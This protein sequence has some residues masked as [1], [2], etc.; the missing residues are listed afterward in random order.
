MANQ[1]FISV[2]EFCRAFAV[3]RTKF[4]QLVAAGEVETA[5]VGRRRLVLVSSALDFASRCM[6]MQK[7]SNS[8]S[9]GASLIDRLPPAL[10]NVIHTGGMKASWECPGNLWEAIPSRRLPRTLNLKFTLFGECVEM[11]KNPTKAALAHKKAREAELKYRALIAKFVEIHKVSADDR[12]IF[13]DLLGYG[14]LTDSLLASDLR[15]RRK[16]GKILGEILERFRA[17]NPQLAFYFWTMTHTRGLTSDRYPKIELKFL[18]SIVDRTFRKLGVS[19]VYIVE[20]QGVGNYP[21]EGKGRTIMVHVHA[22]T[23]TSAVFDLAV[24]ENDLNANGVWLN[25]MGA[26]PVIIKPVTDGQSELGYLC[27]YL[28]KPPYDVKM[29]EERAV[30]NRLKSTEKGYR[31][32]FATRI[33][34]GLFQLDLK[35]IVRACHGGKPIYSEWKRRI[36]F[37]HRSRAKWHSGKLT[38]YFLENFWD[39]YRSKKKRVKY[40]PF[41]FLR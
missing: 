14:R 23:W 22:I 10:C 6:Q 30:G 7:R 3:G 5:K 19:G 11:A 8:V 16:G 26:P 41:E 20:I 27:Y 17:E 1:I 32:E 25:E 39:R 21:R 28:F 33:L 34:E 15:L 40:L 38:N 12:E 24:V 29:M 2:G 4:Y 36:S 37:W 35:E 18:R 31:P 9:S 13:R